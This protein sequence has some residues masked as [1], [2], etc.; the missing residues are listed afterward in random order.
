MVQKA[1]REISM[2]GHLL[3]AMHII[4]EVEKGSSLRSNP[5]NN[6]K[7]HRVFDF[8]MFYYYCKHL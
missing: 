6:I 3:G 7:M 2:V 5:P 1:T 4:A 8:D